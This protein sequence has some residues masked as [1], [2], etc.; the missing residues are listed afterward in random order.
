MISKFYMLSK[1]TFSSFQLCS[2]KDGRHWERGFQVLVNAHERAELLDSKG[3]AN[4]E[5]IRDLALLPHDATACAGRITHHKLEQPG[6]ISSDHPK[7]SE[8]WSCSPSGSV[9]SRVSSIT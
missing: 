2:N 5:V 6:I 9:R 7:L 3:E 1:L 8:F 4:L